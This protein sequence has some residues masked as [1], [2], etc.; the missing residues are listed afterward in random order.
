[1]THKIKILPIH[2][3]RVLAGTKPFEIR[4]NDRPYQKGDKVVL[5]EF[6]E[7]KD[8]L[9]GEELSFYIGDVYPIQGDQVVFGLVGVS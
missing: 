3:A 1:M 5:F 8:L 7:E 4:R 9:T 2:F 6:D